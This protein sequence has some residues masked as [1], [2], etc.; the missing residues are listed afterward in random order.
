MLSLITSVALFGAAHAISDSQCRAIWDPQACNCMVST[1][2]NGN[3]VCQW[4]TTNHVCVPGGGASPDATCTEA[5]THA[6]SGVTDPLTCACT[7]GCLWANGVENGVAFSRCFD[8]ASTSDDSLTGATSLPLFIPDISPRVPSYVCRCRTLH[9][10]SQRTGPEESCHHQYPT[11]VDMLLAELTEPGYGGLVLGALDIDNDGVNEGPVPVEI[12]NAAQAASISGC[13]LD[14]VVTEDSAVGS[15]QLNLADGGVA[16]FNGISWCSDR[17]SGNADGVVT[18][19][20]TFG[21]G[22]CTITRARQT[23]DQEQLPFFGGGNTVGG[24]G[25]GNTMP[26]SGPTTWF[27]DPRNGPDRYVRRQV[28][29]N[30]GANGQ[31]IDLFATTNSLND[32]KLKVDPT[33]NSFVNPF[34]VDV[35]YNNDY[36]EIANPFSGAP[37]AYGC[38]GGAPIL[39]APA[40][41]SANAIT[42]D[43]GVQFFTGAPA[44]A[45]AGPGVAVGGGLTF[46]TPYTNVNGAANVG[47]GVADAYVNAFRFPT[48]GSGTARWRFNSGFTARVTEVANPNSFALTAEDQRVAG[49]IDDGFGLV[50]DNFP[51]VDEDDSGDIGCQCGY[52]RQTAGSAISADAFDLPPFRS[53]AR[54]LASTRAPNGWTCTS[55]SACASSRCEFGG[56][57]AGK[58]CVPRNWADPF[59]DF[60]DEP[61]CFP[62]KSTVRTGLSATVPMSELQINDLVEVALPDGTIA[63]ER[64]IAFLDKKE[65]VQASYIRVDWSAQGTSGTLRLSP[66]HVAHKG[67]SAAATVPV[68]AEELRVGDNLVVRSD[69]ATITATV[70]NVATEAHKGAYAPL[71]ASGNLIVD[72]VHVSSYAN[73]KFP[74][75]A[76]IA[77]KPVQL[78]HSLYS[79]FSTE[80]YLPEE[81]VHPFASVLSVLGKA[82]GAL[83]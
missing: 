81:G 58:V 44:P 52:H 79:L 19:C 55:D 76:N 18:R 3:T 27:L 83:H 20:R 63:L 36:R 65:D 57:L 10:G 1:A 16:G 23:F 69:K 2:V 49:G 56:G 37:M 80:K 62:A 70:T 54:P 59:A 38:G 82:T 22:C 75:A 31:Q 35:F 28:D 47:A 51:G 15:Q 41:A 34:T 42:F 17:G 24:A 26:A 68:F 4:D 32:F 61:F 71:T 64:V 30:N 21:R 6:C 74:A 45:L 11:D 60:K 7:E 5:G 67:A 43:D 29:S 14:D 53:G 66:K 25:S 77:L 40:L 48:A 46:G 33:P 39:A 78:Y 9:S 12:P 73:F 50:A 72:D 13:N 8:G